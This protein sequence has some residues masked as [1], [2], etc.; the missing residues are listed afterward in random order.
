MMNDK[1]TVKYRFLIVR[2]NSGSGI[3]RKFRKI[4]PD[5]PLGHKLP[6]SADQSEA[7][8]RT[9]IFFTVVVFDKKTSTFASQ[10]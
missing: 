8:R 2:V 10:I 6:V 9:K 1:L 3:K 4:R 5:M 7:V